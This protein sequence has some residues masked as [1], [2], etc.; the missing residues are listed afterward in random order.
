M[1]PPSLNSHPPFTTSKTRCPTFVR[2]FFARTGWGF[3]PSQS[4][5]G[6]IPKHRVFTSDA[7]ACPERPSVS[8]E[9]EWGSLFYP[10]SDKYPV[11]HP[12]L[13]CLSQ[14]G[15]G[16]LTFLQSLS[17]GT[18]SRSHNFDLCNS[19]HVD[20]QGQTGSISPSN[21]SLTGVWTG[22][23]FSSEAVQAGN[24]NTVPKSG[25]PCL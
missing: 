9:V 25:E 3:R 13:A 10:D 15:M 23:S 21:A 22:V 14:D 20:N 4:I 19:F 5:F 11:A 17:V 6:V 7:R 16:I 18:C 2:A 1:A 12:C 8:E 24:S